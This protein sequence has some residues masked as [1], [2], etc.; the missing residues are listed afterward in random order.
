MR[1]KVSGCNDYYSMF[2]EDKGD[3]TAGW[4]RE[5]KTLSKT[6]S[7]WSYQSMSELG[8][9]PFLAVIGT[10]GGGGF[11]L[12]LTFSNVTEA[13]LQSL[14]QNHW[15]DSRT[16][17]IFVEIAIYSAQ[18]NLFGVAT[19]SSEWIPTNGIIYFSNIKVARLYRNENDFY[20]MMLVS[21]I[22]LATFL[23]VFLYTEI[24]EV[25]KFRKEYFKDPWNY[26]EV[27]QMVLI[28]TG[29]AALLQRTFFT[30]KAISRMKSDPE[31]FISFM[32]ATT[33]DEIFV[34]LLGLL[35]FI[36]NLKMLK[37]IRF[38]HRIYLFTKTLSKAAMP[39]LSFLIVF[40]IFYIA[41]SFLYY[42]IYGRIVPEYS[43]FLT[44]I[45]TLFNAVMGAFEFETIR[46]NNRLLG[47]IIFFSF[48][49]IMVMILMNVF[50]TILMDSFAEVQADEN[51]KS[52]DAEVVEYML[53]KFKYFF[54]K[55][56][57]VDN[58][59]ER[60]VTCGSSANLPNRS[61]LVQSDSETNTCLS[62]DENW[63]ERSGDTGIREVKG[64]HGLLPFI[65]NAF[66]S[67]NFIH[68]E[69]IKEDDFST[70][71]SFSSLPKT[72][73]DI[74]NQ[75]GVLHYCNE[76]AESLTE[77]QT[78]SVLEESAHNCEKCSR[79]SSIVSRTDSK[80]CGRDSGI[81]SPQ[82]EC[83]Q[84]SC[85]L[86][87]ANLTVN[88]NNTVTTSSSSCSPVSGTER[89]NVK[90]E[91]S[92]ESE[93]S[94]YYE[95]LDRAVDKLILN[96]NRKTVSSKDSSNEL[97][98]PD[99]SHYYQLL[100]TAARE[101][102]Q[103]GEKMLTADEF[104][105]NDYKVYFNNIREM[106]SELVNCGGCLEVEPKLA[107]LQRNFASAAVSDLQEDQIFEQLFISY[108]TALNDFLFETD[109]ATTKRKLLKK[110]EEK[111]KWKYTRH[112]YT[113]AGEKK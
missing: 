44:T 46:D 71:P 111:A 66:V 23:P 5:N 28:L 42:A 34:Y 56:G 59:S 27:S 6:I 11:S 102:E 30:R 97:M 22:F 68:D 60:E 77:R 95:L 45:E 94:H 17:A 51:L 9:L 19:F 58:F 87:V 83:S 55:T 26:L 100:E 20:I 89:W 80:Y 13:S 99:L 63:L 109:R 39:L 88:S 107:E 73:T 93:A 78:S 1:S 62:P 48:N 14:K 7:P 105:L 57:K 18:V 76:P 52:K 84:T 98:D 12:D 41:Y 104:D 47:P 40:F 110:I 10:Y 15:I 25:Y 64:A 91:G 74:Q 70:W 37:L 96:D 85:C 101:Q 8:G 82:T 69:G 50:L 90:S 67:A 38:N 49:M 72:N 61:E 29:A 75:Q 4:K 54:V 108:V 53:Q 106:P 35:V 103:K 33:W 112:M 79:M 2:N 36:A 43:S 32:Q 92:V 86:T 21:E 31:Q 3:Y 81:Y 113:Q 65:Q 24:K 16:R